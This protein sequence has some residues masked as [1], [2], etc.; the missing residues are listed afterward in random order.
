MLYPAFIFTVYAAMPGVNQYGLDGGDPTT[1]GIYGH[2]GAS[3]FERS[4]LPYL[5]RKLKN[6]S[7][8]R[9]R[10]NLNTSNEAYGRF[11]T[12]TAPSVAS[13]RSEYS[14][15]RPAGLPSE[16]DELD[17]HRQG[18]YMYMTGGY[19]TQKPSPRQ[20]DKKDFKLPRINTPH[21]RSSYSPPPA[22]PQ[23][24]IT[25]IQPSPRVDLSRKIEF[26][27][28]K[29]SKIDVFENNSDRLVATFDPQNDLHMP[30]IKSIDLMVHMKDDSTVVL[31]SLP[32]TYWDKLS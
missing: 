2:Y 31:K 9:S 5:P 14:G 27:P 17:R 1:N 4:Y 32:F 6:K 3:Q 23:R 18:E 30:D 26:P 15:F 24:P 8:D 13:P 16:S 7:L 11:W 25:T 20:G 21:H 19:A 22:S 29:P 28:S 12:T 10:Q